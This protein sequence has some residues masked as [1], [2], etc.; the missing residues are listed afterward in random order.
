MIELIEHV[1]SALQRT[2]CR[3]AGPEA[4]SHR[5]AERVAGA[6]LAHA[7]VGERVQRGADEEHGP[8]VERLAVRDHRRARLRHVRE[9]R[10]VRELAAHVGRE[11][12]QRVQPLEVAHEQVDVLLAPLAGPLVQRLPQRSLALQQRVSPNNAI[13]A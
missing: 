4:P 8:G 3:A 7:G 1:R 2:E 10:R 12:E 5:D 9:D 11:H 6:E 13:D